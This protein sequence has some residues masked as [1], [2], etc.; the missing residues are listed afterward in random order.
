MECRVIYFTVWIWGKGCGG[1]SLD[2]S[3]N[4]KQSFKHWENQKKGKIIYKYYDI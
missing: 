2:L 4:E 3:G 1:S